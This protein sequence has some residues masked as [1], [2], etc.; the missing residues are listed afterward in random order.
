MKRARGAVVPVYISDQTRRSGVV[1]TLGEQ[2]ALETRTRTL[3]PKW[4]EGMLQHGYEGVR[5]IEEHVTNTVGWSATTGAV[6]PWIYK[7]IADLYVLDPAMRDRLA[8]LNTTASARLA[9]RLIEAHER[10]F[11][12]PDPETLAALRAAGED[13]EDR[14]EGVSPG[15]AA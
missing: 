15:R 12:T 1:R 3:N 9:N 8:S 6:A 2:V 7:D 13:L 14:L 5:I 4:Y 10:N 11:W